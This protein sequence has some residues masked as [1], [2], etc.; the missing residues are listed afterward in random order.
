[1][2]IYYR[3]YYNVLS[4]VSLTFGGEKFDPKGDYVRKYVPE[5]AKLPNK[6]LN[7]PWEAPDDVLKKAG[8]ILGE[9]YPK[10]LVEHKAAREKALAAYKQS[11]A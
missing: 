2:N 1:M 10:P 4:I 7:H 6:Y 5:L 3:Y 11:R 8:V 9:T